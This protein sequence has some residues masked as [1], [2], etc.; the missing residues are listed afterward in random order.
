MCG[1]F[2]CSHCEDQ[3]E[4]KWNRLKC[5]RITAINKKEMKKRHDDS[6]TVVRLLES[7]LSEMNKANVTMKETNAELKK[8]AAGIKEIATLIKTSKFK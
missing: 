1:D 5:K 7:L 8:M 6:L 4:N 2:C 3:K